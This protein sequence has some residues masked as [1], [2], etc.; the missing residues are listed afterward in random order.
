[1]ECDGERRE[2]RGKRQEERRLC[3]AGARRRR[4]LSPHHLHFSPHL[5]LTSS[6]RWRHAKSPGETQA[7]L[8]PLCPPV[9]FLFFEGLLFFRACYA[10]R[11]EA[12]GDEAFETETGVVL[13]VDDESASGV[14]ADLPQDRVDFP[15]EAPARQV[16][17]A[18][19]FFR[20]RCSIGD[21]ERKNWVPC[22][23]FV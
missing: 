11:H 5:A 10:K 7:R 22:F 8:R 23:L 1:M 2:E 3:K 4:G 21:V 19:D 9:R 13:G 18:E 12:R 14:A 15:A 16:R 6:S 20:P 17:H